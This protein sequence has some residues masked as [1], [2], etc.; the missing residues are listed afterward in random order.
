MSWTDHAK[1]QA[2]RYFHDGLSAG[3]AA[4]H[5][6]VSRSAV[7]GLWHRSGLTKG[8][9]KASKPGTKKPQDPKPKRPASERSLAVNIVHRA[10]NRA[11]NPGEPYRF[12]VDP[13]DADSVRVS[14][15]A[16]VSAPLHQSTCRWPVG[17]PEGADQHFCGKRVYQEGE[18]YCLGH[19]QRGQGTPVSAKSLARDVRRYV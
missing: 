1:A 3:Q 13:V 8:T 17:L 6:K 12:T 9:Q 16:G 7:I 15:L 5:L 18:I 4:K 14:G 19:F 11:E 2:K 10:K